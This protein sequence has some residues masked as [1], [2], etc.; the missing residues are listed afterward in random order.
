[1][2]LER[3]LEVVY[4]KPWAILP[5]KHKAIQTVLE[6]HLERAAFLDPDFLN[7]DSPQE[8]GYE[9]V[10][11]TAVIPIE[12]TI[13][14]KASGLEAMCGAFSL[15][16][17]KADLK[18]VAALPEVKN[19]LLNISSGG[20]TVTGVPEAADLIA[21][22]AKAKNV[23]AYTD[24]CIASA[25][26]WLAS[27]ANAIF[28]SKSAEVGSIG[29]YLALLDITGAMEQQ[30]VKLELFKAG[31]FKAMGIPGAPL[32]EDERAILQASVDKVYQN[33][34]GYVRSK[35]PAVTSDSMQGQM[36]DS[37]D[38]L[39]AGLIDGVINDVNALIDFLNK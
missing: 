38:A 1:M 33:F 13:F 11:N 37:S 22:V 26:Y 9:L 25:A 17:F 8:A 14:N 31:K 6:A 4:T 16:A 2:R 29:V 19:V 34:T 15:E 36:F 18:S 35:R 27:Q 24:D 39:Q 10:G 23:Y 32:S 30:G 7:D 21:Q 3:L 28:I 5:A 12:G 20:G